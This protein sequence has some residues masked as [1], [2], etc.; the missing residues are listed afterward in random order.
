MPLLVDRFVDSR[1]GLVNGRWKLLTDLSTESGSLFDLELDH[2][3]LRD[4]SGRHAEITKGMTDIVR[5]RVRE[6]RAQYRRILSAPR[7]QDLTDQQ[8]LELRSLG[9]L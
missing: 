9:Y 8:Q 1:F 2:Q 5:D 7:S 4:V 6:N 3:E